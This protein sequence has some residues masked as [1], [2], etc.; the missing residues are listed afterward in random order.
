MLY[1]LS[2]DRLYFNM[3]GNQGTVLEMLGETEEAN[4]H[5]ATAFEFRDELSP[6]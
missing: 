1:A 2:H 3:V 4:D 5:F 6:T